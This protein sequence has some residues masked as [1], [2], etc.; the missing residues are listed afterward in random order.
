MASWCLANLGRLDAR[1]RFLCV[2]VGVLPDLDGLGILVSQDAYWD[3]HHLLCHN[4]LFG[5]AISASCAMFSTNK[6]RMV[7]WCL[8]VF[9]AHLLLDLLGS[10]EGWQ[11]SYLW[12]FSRT[13]LEFSCAWGLYS[14]Q[15]FAAGVFFLIWTL[16]LAVRK[17]RTFIEYPL[18]SLD[19]QIVTVLRRRR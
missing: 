12:P 7:L 8:A 16:L 9:H 17:G 15:N 11:I 18:P 4:L 2:A 1:E 19:Q 3:Y 10:G 6:A 14:W 13:S 5:V